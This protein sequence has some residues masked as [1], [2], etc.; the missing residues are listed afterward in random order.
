MPIVMAFIP[1]QSVYVRSKYSFIGRELPLK[2]LVFEGSRAL[3][4]DKLEFVR[5]V[6]A[7]WVLAKGSFRWGVQKRGVSR[8]AT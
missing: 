7:T 6:S 4:K 5:L 8:S 3:S 2:Q 1:K